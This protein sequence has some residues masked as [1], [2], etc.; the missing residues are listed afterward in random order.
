MVDDIKRHTVLVI[1]DE[2]GPRESLRMLLKNDYQ[3]LSADSV[4]GGLD[5]LD[6][7][8]VDVV[9]MDI[10]MPNKNGIDGLRAIREKFPFLSVVLITGFGSLETAQEA[11][12]LG[13][14]DYIRKPYD[15]VEMRE[16]I[17]RNVQRSRLERWR[18]HAEKELTH[19]NTKLLDELEQKNNLATL[20]QKS[21]EFVHDLRSPLTAMLGYVD[22]LTR[23]LKTVRE[24]LG[25]HWGETTEYLGYI[26]KSVMRC[27]ELSDL[28]MN[29]G[30]TK[31]QARNPVDVHALLEDVIRSGHHAA[32]AKGVT[33]ELN[34]AETSDPLEI[35]RLQ[36]SRA[37]T[38]I[39]LNAIEAVPETG[40][41]V[42]FWHRVANG[43]HEIGIK[44]NGCG[45]TADQ[46]QHVFEPFFTT[47]IKNGTGLGLAIVKE[48]IDAHHGTIQ[49]ESKVNEGSEFI[50][51]LAVGKTPAPIEATPAN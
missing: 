5:L 50:V 16:V 41:Q 8:E 19:L 31:P 42:R 7:N 21:M 34:A 20:G 27:K 44:D 46:I 22:L 17:L 28:W 51:R 29:R 47:K 48:A 6:Q 4:D 3:V 36:I 43:M 39:L 24:G 9:A 1:D 26:E 14:N 45:M 37:L 23:E 15:A 25:D 10:R 18:Q 11:I 38:N 13:A 2:R 49:V 40:G 12:R 33:V 35:N 32:T 30:K